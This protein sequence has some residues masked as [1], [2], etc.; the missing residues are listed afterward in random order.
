MENEDERMEDENGK[1]EED[2]KLKE[3]DKTMEDDSRTKIVHCDECGFVTTEPVLLTKHIKIKH[4]KISEL[5]NSP[6]DHK[7]S[8]SIE[9]N[10]LKLYPCDQCEFS[11][12]CSSSLRKHI[13]LSHVGSST[14][15]REKESVKF[16]LEMCFVKWKMFY[17]NILKLQVENINLNT[18][19]SVKTT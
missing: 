15:S 7:D 2:S 3:D 4:D 11:S 12:G 18:D 17:F 6:S 16:V 8:H 1:I 5:P 14:Q 19:L 10:E 13:K 9:T